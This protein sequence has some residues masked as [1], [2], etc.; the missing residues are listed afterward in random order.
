MKDTIDM[1][2]IAT[3][4]AAAALLAPLAALAHGNTHGQA[5]PRAGAK[6]QKPWGIAG[7]RK[8]VTRTIAVGMADDMRFT[9]DRIEVRR[10]E[11]I[12]FVAANKGKVLHELVI[13][14]PDELDAHAAM[15]AKYPN[16]EHDEP[17]MAHV[18]P[19]RRGDIVWHFN[20]AGEFRFACLVAGHYQAGMVGTLIVK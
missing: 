15:M 6:D 13:A 4:I 18:K 3:L 8:A 2:Q 12:R 5:A 10:G 7:D 19:G 14:T 9:P 16:M 1:K 20:R 11:T 17:Y